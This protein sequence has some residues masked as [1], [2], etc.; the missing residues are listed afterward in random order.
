[1]PPISC[2]S[3]LDF[4]TQT[5]PQSPVQPMGQALV[6]NGGCALGPQNQ[7]V[8]SVGHQAWGPL[9]EGLS[10]VSTRRWQWPVFSGHPG[11]S[12][13][14][15]WPTL[16]GS[17]ASASWSGSILEGQG[18]ASGGEVTRVPRVKDWVRISMD[19][20]SSTGFRENL[21][22]VKVIHQGS[23]SQGLGQGRGW[24][25]EGWSPLGQG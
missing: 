6:L 9:S 16:C 15:P 13:A 4:S 10:T 22:K 25:C 24:A 14:S 19:Q 3:S 5:S 7:G 12:S 23:Q 17:P 11:H 20:G 18:K 2:P 8:K 1:M 21:R